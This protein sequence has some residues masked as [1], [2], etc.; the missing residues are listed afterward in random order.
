MA[1]RTRTVQQNK[2]RKKQKNNHNNN[3]NRNNKKKSEQQRKSTRR[4][5][6]TTPWTEWDPEELMVTFL[7]RMPQKPDQFWRDYTTQMVSHWGWFMSH[8]SF[9][10][11]YYKTLLTLSPSKA[12]YFS[13]VVLAM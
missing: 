11:P 9:D 1:T 8:M 6:A 13:V 2:S 12:S 7:E 10:L 5:I 3:E 4:T